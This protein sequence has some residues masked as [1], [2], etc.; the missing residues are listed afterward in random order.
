MLFAGKGAKGPGTDQESDQTR[1]LKQPC[2]TFN[3]S[4][5]ED[6]HGEE[7]QEEEQEE[8]T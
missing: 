3:T 2:R 1:D 4:S 8:V 7:E 5:E 6:N